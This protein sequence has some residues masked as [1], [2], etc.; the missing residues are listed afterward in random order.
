M[1]F[2]NRTLIIAASTL[3]LS[4]SAVMA[5]TSHEKTLTPH[6]RHFGDC[7]HANKGK[8]GEDYKAA[9]H[10]CLM[11]EKSTSALTPQQQKMKDCN[12]NAH[13]HSLH[14]EARKAF[15]KNCLKD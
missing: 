13:E 5:E 2:R 8:H 1:L 9:M 15:M 11:D 6:E 7:S 10:A 12:K 3:A 14:G 4:T